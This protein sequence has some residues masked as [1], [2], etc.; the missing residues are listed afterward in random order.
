LL[1]P[2]KE[3]IAGRFNIPYING[4]FL[5]PSII[6]T[7]IILLVVYGGGY[8]SEAFNFDFSNDEAYKAGRLTFMDLATPK[9]SIII[10]W[11][12]CILLS[13]LTIPRKYSLIPLM[14][15]TTCLYLLTG[16]TKS[17]WAWFLGWLLLGL[18]I[19][20][21]YGYRHSRLAVK[22]G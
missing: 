14:G 16:M 9:I 4:Q 17:N 18:V 13:A 2:R 5:Y 22:A 12:I 11:T 3:K 10:F 15:V 19:Y 6:A 21:I 7:A 8:F 20:F 1:I